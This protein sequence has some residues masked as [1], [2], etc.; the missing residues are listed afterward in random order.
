MVPF[1]LI[2]T[3]FA[4]ISQI[5][6]TKRTFISINFI[7]ICSSIFS[8][9]F[10]SLELPLER[11]SLTFYSPPNKLLLTSFHFT[12]SFTPGKMCK[13]AARL[14]PQGW[15]QSLRQTHPRGTKVTHETLNMRHTNSQTEG[16]LLVQTAPVD[17]CW[18]CRSARGLA[19]EE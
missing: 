12:I 9:D 11:N 3:H 8:L 7:K 4:L 19:A 16:L 18:G 2:M 13:T 5:K 10:Y 15:H 17:V 14:T 1:F 6:T